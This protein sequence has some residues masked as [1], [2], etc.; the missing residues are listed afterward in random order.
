MARHDF[1]GPYD[2]M[3]TRAADLHEQIGQERR[4]QLG[5]DDDVELARRAGALGEWHAELAEIFERAETLIV[6][7]E[8]HPFERMMA[9]AAAVAHKAQAHAQLQL[10]RQHMARAERHRAKGLQASF[11][12]PF[13]VKRVH[14]AA[15]KAAR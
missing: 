12:D 14:E 15:R 2:S 10:G 8:G 1:G 7:E 6:T 5:A 13:A 4:R 3:E 9:H 11:T